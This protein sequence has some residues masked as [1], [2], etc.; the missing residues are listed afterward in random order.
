[1]WVVLS[2]F[3]TEITRRQG[4]FDLVTLKRIRNR[5]WLELE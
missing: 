2:S 1:M 4:R 5:E 3:D